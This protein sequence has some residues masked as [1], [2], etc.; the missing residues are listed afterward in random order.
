[1]H[2]TGRTWRPPYEADSCIIQLTAGCTWHRCSFC[3]LYENEPFCLTSPEAFER[4]LEEEM[5]IRSCWQT[6]VIRRRILQNNAKS[7]TKQELSII[8]FI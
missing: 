2:F 3:N 7:W 8:L 5:M 6:R 1:M 4:D